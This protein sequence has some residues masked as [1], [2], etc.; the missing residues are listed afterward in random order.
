[1]GAIIQCHSCYVAF[2]PLCAR[3]MG[4]EMQV[5]EVEDRYEYRAY[6]ARHSRELK[7][8][9]GLLPASSEVEL[10]G[11]KILDP[12]QYVLNVDLPPLTLE[13]PSGC[14]RCEPLHKSLGWA[15][16]DKGSGR[17]F[18]S[19]KGFWIP[20][21]PRAPSVRNRTRKS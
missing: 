4:Y 18:S 1:M 10:K 21:P 14:S 7:P 5:A 19:T 11:E 8:G 17:G 13:C 6:C 9:K 2:H 12:S 16:E 3:M 15:R 20:L